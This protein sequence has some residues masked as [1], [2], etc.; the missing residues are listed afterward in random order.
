MPWWM[1]PARWWL[2]REARRI[3]RQVFAMLAAR[4]DQIL[5]NLDLIP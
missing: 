1:M 5:R 3:E 4:R 2:K